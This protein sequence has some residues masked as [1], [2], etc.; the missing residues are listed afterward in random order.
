MKDYIL[1]TPIK[2]TVGLQ[3]NQQTT[4]QLDS[5]IIKI[6]YNDNTVN[7]ELSVQR[8]TDD[9]LSLKQLGGSR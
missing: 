9:V 4:W 1:T 5:T 2:L 8:T 3:G 6:K 7:F